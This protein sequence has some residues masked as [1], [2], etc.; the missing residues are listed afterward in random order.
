[1]KSAEDRKK[2]VVIT[3]VTCA[4]V[5]VLLYAIVN[6][7]TVSALLSS[8]MSVFSPILIGFAL[9]YMLNP[10]LRLFEFK[11][12]KKIPK[13]NV[14]RGLSIF[15][16]YIV[17]IL[18]VVA[19]LFLLVP[20]LVDAIVDLVNNFDEYVDTTIYFINDIINKFTDN[21]V[22]KEYVNQEAIM[23]VVKKFFSTSESIFETVL[24]YISEYGMGLVVGVTNFILGVFISIYVLISKEKLQAQLRKFGKAVFNENRNRKLG[25]YITLTHRTFSSYFVG[26]IIGALIA[27]VL[28]L[29]LML[30]FGVPYPLLVATV[31]G[32]TDIIPIFGPILGAIPSFFIIFIV[33]PGKAVVFVILLLVVQQLEGNVISPK[34]LGEA[35]G[36]SSLSVMIAIIVMGDY[37]GFVGMIIGVPVFAVGITIVKELIDTRLRRKELSTDTA[38][39]YLKDSIADPHDMHVPL[40]KKIFD[41]LEKTFEQVKS[42][43]QKKKPD[44]NGEQEKGE[45]NNNDREQS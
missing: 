27:F 44:E 14:V 45:E 28:M 31:I 30:I 35:T 21:D 7:T 33:D 19:F 3:L 6:I 43:L 8:T 29:V 20:Q 5:F 25:K 36:I 10:I 11:I 12:Y 16:T 26:K 42:K 22:A 15:S 38:D 13:K 32:I 2:G 41:N 37:F 23:N 18:F 34:V 17:A 1:M 40:G 39:Y 9:A 24:T 4:I